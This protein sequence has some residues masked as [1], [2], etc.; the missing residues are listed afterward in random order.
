MHELACVLAAP[1]LFQLSANGLAIAVEEGLSPSNS[2]GNS[3]FLA[4]ACP[5]FGF[6]NRLGMNE[7]NGS[8]PFSLS[9][10]LSLRLLSTVLMEDPKV[11]QLRSCAKSLEKGDD[12]ES[13][14]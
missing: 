10:S 5:N 2:H 12:G 4:L 14:N 1:F 11:R 8:L 7:Q 9:L 13:A 6:C 3:W